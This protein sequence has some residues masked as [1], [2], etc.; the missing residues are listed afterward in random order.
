MWKKLKMEDGLWEMILTVFK[1]HGTTTLNWVGMKGADASNLEKQFWLDNETKDKLH[2]NTVHR[3][4]NL[5]PTGEWVSDT[6]T[7]V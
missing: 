2:T 6:E 5:F 7:T 3:L 1:M 4:V